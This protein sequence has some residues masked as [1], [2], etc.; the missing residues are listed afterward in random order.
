MKQYKRLLSLLL[1]L[2]LT[3]SLAVPTAF[4]EENNTDNSV[5]YDLRY[6]EPA[7]LT[8]HEN[9]TY[10][11]WDANKDKLAQAY[12]NNTINSLPMYFNS[13]N[14]PTFSA[15]GINYAGFV[16]DYFSLKIQSPGATGVYAIDILPYKS[17]VAARGADVYVLPADTAESAIADG[18]AL[19]KDA[20]VGNSNL[21]S[22]SST[23][24]SVRIGNFIFENSKEY[25]IVLKP[26]LN[27]NGNTNVD[28]T[29]AQTRADFTLAQISLSF[30]EE[31][32]DEETPEEEAIVINYS[33]GFE[34]LSGQQKNAAANPEV[35]IAFNSENKCS[36]LNISTN[37]GFTAGATSI[38]ARF[39]AASYEA[40][41][42][43]AVKLQDVNAGVYDM[44]FDMGK[45]A[46]QGGLTKVYVVKSAAYTSAVSQHLGTLQAGTS[47]TKD[48]NAAFISALYADGGVLN[49]GF[50]A[51]IDDYACDALVQYQS[52]GN[53]TFPEDGDYVLVFQSAGSS[54]NNAGTTYYQFGLLNLAMTFV[55]AVKEPVIID[56]TFGFETL[57]GQVKNGAANPE[58]EIP[59]KS[60]TKCSYLN[61]STNRGFTCGAV[62]IVARFDSASYGYGSWMAFRIYDVAAGTYDMT[63]DLGPGASSGGL[64]KVYVVKSSAYSNAIADYFSKMNTGS[65]LTASENTAI[66]TALYEDKA[67]LNAGKE[68]I[69]DC[70]KCDALEQY[71]SIGEVT[72]PESGDYVLMFQCAGSSPNSGTAAYQLGLLGLSMTQTEAGP[73]DGSGSDSDE[74]EPG[75]DSD[76]DESGGGYVPPESGSDIIAPVS[77]EVV[78]KNVI[79]T[80]TFLKYNTWVNPTNGHNYLYQVLKGGTLVVYD[81][82]LGVIID[83]ENNINS[84][85]RATYIDANGMLWICGTSRYLCK[86]D[87]FTGTCTQVPF[88]SDLFPGITSFSAYGLTGDENGNLYFG[89]YN[90]GYLG[91]YN[92]NT[93]V[94]SQISDQL[95]AT[96][97]TGKGPDATHCGFGGLAV[98][99]GYLYADI[100]GNA[101]EDTVTIHQ[102]IKYDIAN[103]KIV[104]WIDISKYFTSDDQYIT[105]LK[106]VD[107]ILFAN[108]GNKREKTA[109]ITIDTTGANMVHIDI[110][111]LEKGFYGTVSDEID[112][113]AYLWGFYNSDPDNN[114][115]CMFEYDIAARKATPILE[116]PQNGYFHGPVVAI[117]GD[118][119]LPGVSIMGY[120]ANSV[121]GTFDILMYNPTTKQT[122]SKYS[123]TLQGVGSG[124]PVRCLTTDP[125][126][127][128]I[129]VGAYG[130]NSVAQFNIDSGTVTNQMGTYDHQTDNLIWY[131]GYLYV[132]NYNEGYITRLDVETKEA[133]PLLSLYNTAFR[134]RRMHSIAAGDG[135]VF[136]GSV[137]DSNRYG[138]V[139]VWYDLEKE[140]T[141]VA[142]GPN[143]ED[144]FYAKTYD[145]E[146]DQLLESFVWHSA[147]T[148]EVVDFDDDNDGQDDY[149]IKVNGES[150]QRFNGVIK[151][152]VIIQMFYQDGCIYGVTTKWGGSNSDAYKYEECA[153]IFVYDVAAMKVIATYDLCDGIT[154]LKAPILMVDA[155][156]ADPTVEGKFWGVVCD[157][158]FS[159]NFDTA[160]ATFSNVKE[161]LSM[162]KN[163]YNLGG[164][165]WSGREIIFDGEFMYVTFGSVGTLMV[166]RSNVQEYHLLSYDIP[167]KMVQAADGNLYFVNNS[168]DL[169]VLR[170]A[171]ETAKVK[172]PSEA[173]AVQAMIDALD[174]A[175]NI[176]LEDEPAV[177]AARNAYDSLTENGKA[178]VTNISK[179]TAAEAAIAPLRAAADKAAAD[180]VTEKIEALGEVTLESEEAIQATRDAYEA[181]TDSQKKLVDTTKL[182]AAETKL[183]EL[184]EAAANKAAADAVIAKIQ[185]IGTV[186]KDSEEAIKAARADYE[187]LTADQKALVSNLKVLEA[188]EDAYAELIKDSSNPGTGDEMSIA[189]ITCMLL[190]SLLSLSALL[191][192]QAQKRYR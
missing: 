32:S 58:I 120:K 67:V 153:V 45:G 39:N 68:A 172:D 80:A 185:A 73:D 141:Y 53:V 170:I 173:A 69:I 17:S 125:S 97:E 86:Y 114:D 41:A 90:K 40:G 107:G 162:G 154:G 166:N 176:T 102:I 2:C 9:Q 92:T 188:A 87:P 160:T 168:N 49:E 144:V 93:G 130:V 64:A 91:M 138:G 116:I 177:V 157:T 143:P 103:Q 152:Q 44:T 131:D 19:T 55:E 70:Y 83:V 119:R 62:S 21:Q 79:S 37:R 47:L 129:Y 123:N 137:P 12:A 46:S 169:Y 8:Y 6:I 28:A 187:A 108:D 147:L 7:E 50:E 29:D 82:D 60:E 1:A 65:S 189:V 74:D 158:L 25:L 24:T 190:V 23:P 118:D 88:S 112:G 165:A 178:M 133:T 183:A 101:N 148:G 104:D 117:A 22:N 128:N 36:Y 18:S 184:K 27:R 38:L 54:S 98:R 51:V 20:L 56:Y 115:L 72:F 191:L 156:A 76:E 89:T 122:V 99:D 31:V 43:M 180:A 105:S 33:F 132:G 167:T 135:K 81:M 126:G 61:I 96:P 57:S 136:C 110:E 113:K 186:S 100:R 121:A 34:T 145:W 149:N 13:S 134:Q 71:Q 30:L 175:A 192:F 42:W 140:L 179:L 95:D 139:L 15:T 182:V 155:L 174:D 48:E 4:A 16:G 181:L 142:A 164:V 10:C 59:F 35:E 94:F 171:D 85:A 78:A 106:M 163:S 66:F 75:G 14:G 146:N 127:K 124:N 151:N 5:T 159:F 63:F 52:I 109:P 11:K 26:T 111:G 77:G 150:Q 84:H 161:E 3:L